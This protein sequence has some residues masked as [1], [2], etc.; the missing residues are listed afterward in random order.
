MHG[1][2]TDSTIF[3][4][5]LKTTVQSQYMSQTKIPYIDTLCTKQSCQTEVNILQTTNV[6][7]DVYEGTA[8]SKHDWRITQSSDKNIQS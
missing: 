1:P 7:E 2:E 5:A 6:S 8:M 4:E 3:P